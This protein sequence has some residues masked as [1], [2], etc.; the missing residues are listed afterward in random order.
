M[1]AQRQPMGRPCHVFDYDGEYLGSFTVWSAAHEWAHLQAAL[2]GVPGP[3]EVE[4]RRAGQ[5]HRIWA[6]HCEP[7]T[8]PRRGAAP[9]AGGVDAGGVDA[10]ES[11][12]GAGPRGA[13]GGARRTAGEAGG[14]PEG[15]DQPTTCGVLDALAFNPP[16]PRRPS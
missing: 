7:L 15:F 5:R 13:E 4:D 2:G 8:V 12:I 6:D 10:G 16:R 9:D 11:L 3:L 1:A 14:P